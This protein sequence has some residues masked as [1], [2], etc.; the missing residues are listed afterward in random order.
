MRSDILHRVHDV[1]HATTGERR[2]LKELEEETGI[3]ATNWKNVWTG[4]QRPTAHMIEA[5]ARRWPQYA[6]WLATGLTDAQNGHTAPKA[7]W[8]ARQPKANV[9]AEE[10]AVRYFELKT[11]I[12][13]DEYGPDDAAV[14]NYVQVKD[15]SSEQ[16]IEAA[17][18]NPTAGA[19][20]KVFRKKYS[21]LDEAI[22]SLAFKRRQSQL[23]AKFPEIDIKRASTDELN[24]LLEKIQ[25]ERLTLAK[26]PTSLA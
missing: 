19:D 3:P 20:V 9:L 1:I 22:A 2:R 8:T 12:Q 14:H 15:P 13:D 18:T 25:A 17:T 5:L 7:A 23:Q 21:D 24:V 4:K 10:A 11:L 6:F 16:I 26:L